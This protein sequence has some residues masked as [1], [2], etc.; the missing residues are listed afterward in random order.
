MENNQEHFI[1]TLL[2]AVVISSILVAPFLFLE[3]RLGSQTYSSF[4]YQLFA[5]L[6]ILPVAFVITFSPFV[7]SLRSRE[8]VITNPVTLVVRI[9][10]L[11]LFLILWIA[12]VRDQMPCF[13]GVPNCD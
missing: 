9:A 3:L 11:A 6:W 5:I 4:P 7:R 2:I 13:L 12:L 1:S 10:F 8:S